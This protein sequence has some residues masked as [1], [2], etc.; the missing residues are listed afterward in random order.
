[1]R[2]YV[3]CESHYNMYKTLFEVYNY[4]VPSYGFAIIIAC[5]IC[6]FLVLRHCPQYLELNDI[7]NFCLIALCSMFF[8]DK[9]IFLAY[10]RFRLP[11]EDLIHLSNQPVHS[12]YG[13]LWMSLILIFL[14]CM[15]KK[16]LVWA[17]LDFLLYYAILALAIQRI[18]GCFLAG[19]CYGLPTDL[20]WGVC[21]P[22]NSPAGIVYPN[23]PV[24]PTQLYYGVSALLIYYGLY[25]YQKRVR[26]QTEGNVFALGIMGL[27]LSYFIISFFRGDQLNNM[28]YTS[29]IF[30]D[31]II[32]M[33]SFLFGVLVYSRIILYAVIRRL[34][35]SLPVMI[36]L[37]CLPPAYA[38]DLLIK[39]TPYALAK[40]GKEITIE[41]VANN[42]KD[43]H[44]KG[45]ITVSFDSKV[46][47]LKHDN[48]IK[49]FQEGSTYYNNKD[50][51]IT[52][53]QLMINKDF[54][55]WAPNAEKK[56]VFKIIPVQTGILKIF[57]R[58]SLYLESG[59]KDKRLNIPDYS[60]TKD[61]LGYQVK[62]HQIF[63]DE[64]YGFYN[65]FLLLSKYDQI[66]NSNDFKILFNRLLKEPGNI[67]LLR[68][69]GFMDPRHAKEDI[70]RLRTIIG[71]NPQ[72]MQSPDLLKNVKRLLDNP[73]NQKA[74]NFFGLSQSLNQKKQYADAADQAK[75]FILSLQGGFS[76]IKNIESDGDID[77]IPSHTDNA[78][79][80][81]CQNKTYSFS[82]TKNIVS[83]MAYKLNQIKPDAKY[84]KI[85]AIL[86]EDMNS[87]KIS[88]EKKDKY[89]SI[90]IS[91][92]NLFEPIERKAIASNINALIQKTI[93][94]GIVRAIKH[95]SFIKFNEPGHTI[96][97][98]PE[99]LDKLISIT[100]N[101]HK[102]PDEKKI[103]L[104][105]KLMQPNK[106][107]AILSGV[108]L[109]KDD[110][111]DVRLYVFT[112]EHDV[113]QRAQSF[114]KQAF[115]CGPSGF[116]NRKICPDVPEKII[117][118]IKELFGA[119]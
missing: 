119:L 115:F 89:G 106:V 116:I 42:P 21:F 93:H 26:F 109:I 7:V 10:H 13:T 118:L 52:I 78:I 79:A 103:T 20:P 6:L 91:Y 81:R 9:L 90:Y 23:T 105:E 47:M 67:S 34:Y 71:D 58:V 41:I 102:S 53:S 15:I 50:Q 68:H 44:L 76:L 22:A 84:N 82:I 64:S 114:Q 19:C 43:E 65:N 39:T 46:I 49:V 37:F 51:R 12:F 14:Y 31:K 1:M 86:P 40:W 28:D 107:D 54:N 69:F 66:F 38:A 96:E 32:S 57:I 18:F 27:S 63:V 80:I 2:G 100:L 113:F 30:H 88:N 95:Y 108:L 111:V 94:D 17:T 97:N 59:S 16:L 3:K 61:Q 8:A 4:K 99:N 29:F 98:N 104:T 56:I 25:I 85:L 75:G 55:S 70:N 117:S 62:V 83:E 73:E 35:F 33:G 36:M 60:T 92:I 72:V 77:F 74:R 5:L 11:L 101:P 45:D 87:T 112:R 48:T 24:H 110:T